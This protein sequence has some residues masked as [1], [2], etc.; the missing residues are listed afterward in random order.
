MSEPL[1][2]SASESRLKLSQLLSIAG[3]EQPLSDWHECIAA[4]MFLS[5]SAVGLSAIEPYS[6]S[7]IRATLR[8]LNEIP[9]AWA[10]LACQQVLG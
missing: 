1:E 10:Q 2:V 5:G 6:Q 4:E 8:A 9:D 7:A 3:L